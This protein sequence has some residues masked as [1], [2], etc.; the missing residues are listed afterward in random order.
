M[1]KTPRK[2]PSPKGRVPRYLSTTLSLPV[3]SEKLERREENERSLCLLNS[4]VD[5]FGWGWRSDIREENGREE[6]RA[7]E[8]TKGDFEG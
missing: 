7:D 8:K 3:R 2:V 6:G 1:A 4:S 5:A